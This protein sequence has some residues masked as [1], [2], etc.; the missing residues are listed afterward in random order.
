[1]ELRQL[2]HFVAIAEELHFT[3]AATR[4]HVV[5]SSLSASIRALEHE[6]GGVLF[7][8]DSRHVTLT[9]AGRALLPA[10][11][12]A[13]AAAD[14]GRDA[15]AGVRGVLGGQLHVGAIQTL[16]VI[17]LPALLTAFR[18]AHPGVII[19][20]SHDAA[21]VLA[22]A[23]ADAQLDIAF[24]DGPTDPARLTRV[25]IGHD[26]L[27]LAVAQ[28]DPLAERAS[29]GLGDPALRD[30]DFVDYR[31]DSALRAQ[32][33]VACAA[34]GLARRTVCEAQNMQYLAELVQ[35][36]LGISVLPPMSV[37]AVTA[38]VSVISITPPL[39]RDICAVTAATRPPTGAAQALLGILQAG[40]D[41]R[42]AGLDS[43]QGQATV[44]ASGP[45]QLA[46]RCSITGAARL[47][48][49]SRSRHNTAPAAAVPATTAVT[50][51]TRAPRPAADRHGVQAQ[52][53]D[54]RTRQRGVRPADRARR[55][56]QAGPDE[57]RRG[58]HPRAE[59]EPR[60]QRERRAVDEREQHQQAG[61]VLAVTAGVLVGQRRVRD[62][63][64]DQRDDH[65]GDLDEVV[66]S[67]PKP[68]RTRGR[69]V[70]GVGHERRREP[71]HRL[72]VH[73]PSV[74]TA[75]R[76]PRP[77]HGVSATPYPSRGGPAPG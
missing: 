32:I 51:V 69:R 46:A 11:H 45:A 18:R 24:I 6:V 60:A 25:E 5:Q 39:R 52:A 8:R 56:Y 59:R 26:D 48:D 16:G 9:Q 55:N 4:V 23:A 64:A 63:E 17:D 72:H 54:Q 73:A 42:Q 29:I 41:S 1:M 77:P 21:A 28:G 30:R 7:V 47:P 12:R 36:G 74:G 66:P 53:V 37:R 38:Q 76:K 10:A 62:G 43:R 75:T 27:V 68:A 20:L 33:D 50:A 34:A 70:R 71:P 35:H 57:S 58:K 19:R 3:R 40:L 31:A 15:V 61:G 44:L 49:R 13:L 67:A 2:A 14:E 65:V 22:G